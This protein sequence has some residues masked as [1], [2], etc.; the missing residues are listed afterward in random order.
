MSNRNFSAT[1]VALCLLG[2]AIVYVA[3]MAGCVAQPNDQKTLEKGHEQTVHV[4]VSVFSP[5]TPT[6]QPACGGSLG[7]ATGNT[8]TTTITTTGTGSG[9]QEGRASGG[10]PGPVTP[11]VSPTLTIPA[12]P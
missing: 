11:T 12:I 8:V 3:S 5:A 1:V 10:S 9:G 7:N 4:S 2:A 6:T